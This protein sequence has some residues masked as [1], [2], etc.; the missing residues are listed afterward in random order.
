MVEEFVENYCLI[1]METSAKTGENVDN[2]ISW[3][4]NKI[5]DFIKEDTRI[6]FVS[7]LDQNNETVYE[8]SLTKKTD[9]YDTIIKKCIIQMKELG[10]NENMISVQDYSASIRTEKDFSVVVG[11]ENVVSKDDL[12]IASLSIAQL[13]KEDF[14]PPENFKEQLEEVV[15]IA[16]LQHLNKKK[17]DD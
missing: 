6:S 10:A 3:M 17:R 7:I 2:A 11:A 16:L 1:S 13:I 5:V 4:F 12:S 8:T 9:E 15:N 14:Y